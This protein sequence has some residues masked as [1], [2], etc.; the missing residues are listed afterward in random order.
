MAQVDL[1]TDVQQ[2][3]VGQTWKDMAASRSLGTVYTNTTGKPIQVV[4]TCAASNALTFSIGGAV[5]AQATYGSSSPANSV[6][7]IIP[8]GVTYSVAGSI[9]KWWELR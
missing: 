8:N 1:A 9:S 5:V 3:G 2:L 6:S 4:V 7:L